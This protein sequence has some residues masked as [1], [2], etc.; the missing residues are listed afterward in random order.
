MYTFKQGINLN[1][2][3]LNPIKRNMEEGEFSLMRRIFRDSGN[4]K[5]KRDN[6]GTTI[7]LT[8]KDNSSYI[9]NKKA[10][11]VA[12]QLGKITSYRSYD[13]VYVGHVMRKLHT[14]GAVVGKKKVVSY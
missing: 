5:D 9:H 14:S 8:Y 1:N 7:N 4:P 13:P 11:S 2:V 6:V 3:E 12:T 10:N